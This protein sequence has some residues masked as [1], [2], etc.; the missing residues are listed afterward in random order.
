MAYN[1]D[2]IVKQKATESGQRKS[3]PFPVPLI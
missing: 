1:Y 3:S 2:F